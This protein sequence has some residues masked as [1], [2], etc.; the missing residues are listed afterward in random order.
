MDFRRCA[1]SPEGKEGKERQR[2]HRGRRMDRL[3]Q[4][5]ARMGV[6]ESDEPSK[7]HIPRPCFFWSTPFT[8]NPVRCVICK[9]WLALAPLP[10]LETNTLQAYSHRIAC[11][12]PVVSSIVKPLATRPR[13]A[14]RTAMAWHGEPGLWFPAAWRVGDP[15]ISATS[16]PATYR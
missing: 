10:G 7:R 3:I 5:T 11:N 16:A 2:L 13:L 8:F 15:A 12:V 14:R 9:C 4:C 6:R 1:C